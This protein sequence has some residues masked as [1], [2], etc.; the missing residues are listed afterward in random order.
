M[1]V[2]LRSG[3][4]PCHE[5]NQTKGNLGQAGHSVH[6]QDTDHQV[7]SEA[8]VVSAEDAG[9]IGSRGALERLQSDGC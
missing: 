3:H 9:G 6:V 5:F 8:E 4:V 1:A 2:C 7:I